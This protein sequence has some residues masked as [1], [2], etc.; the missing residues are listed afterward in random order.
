MSTPLSCGKLYAPWR[1][2]DLYTVR[3]VLDRP[4]ELGDPFR[5]VLA[6]DQTMPRVR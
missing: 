3:T 1:R 4:V 5:G 6:A 2:P